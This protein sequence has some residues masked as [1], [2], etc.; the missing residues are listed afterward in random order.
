MARECH[1]I[2]KMPCKSHTKKA[3]PLA[4]FGNLSEVILAP[5]VLSLFYFIL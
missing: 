4:H 2:E 5:F 3:G 1:I